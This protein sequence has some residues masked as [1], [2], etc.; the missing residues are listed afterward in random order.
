MRLVAALFL[1]YGFCAQAQITAGALVTDAFDGD[2]LSVEATIWPDLVWTGSVRVKGVDTPE[3]QGEC[4][5]EQTL[6]IEARD[7]VRVLLMNKAVR[8]TDVENDKYGGRVMARVYFREGESW[9]DLADRLIEMGLGQAYL[10]GVREEW[11][12]DDQNDQ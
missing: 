2:T 3:I 5:E 9:V 12:G 1:F 10:G 11:C 7:Y 8:L 6:A 4:K